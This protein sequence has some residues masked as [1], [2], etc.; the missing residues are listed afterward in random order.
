M[1]CSYNDNITLGTEIED[2]YLEPHFDRQTVCISN[3]HEEANQAGGAKNQKPWLI[4]TGD[5]M[6]R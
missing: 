2:N 5:L 4:E 3:T 1:L 6:L